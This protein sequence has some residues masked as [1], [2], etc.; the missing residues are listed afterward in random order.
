VRDTVGLAGDVA[1]NPLTWVPIGG[2][3][4]AI[5]IPISAPNA[6]R[7]VDSRLEVYD[8]ATENAVDPYISL[9]SSYIQYREKAASK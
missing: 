4:Q 5:A 7:N 8:A 9:R 6:V 3:A 1:L 2:V